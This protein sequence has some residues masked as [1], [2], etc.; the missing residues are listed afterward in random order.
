MTAPVA[1]PGPYSQRPSGGQPVRALPDADYGEQTEY[2]EQQKSASM[3]KTD[4]LPAAPSPSA[5]ADAAPPAQ[6]P[7]PAPLYAPGDPSIPATAGAPL[8]SGP[9]SLPGTTANEP[10]RLSEHLS[11]YAVG[12]NSDALAWLVNTLTRMGQ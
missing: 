2:Q 5:V 1:G 7:M 8:G 9:N 12:D 3:S 11:Q 10:Y 4:N 6:R